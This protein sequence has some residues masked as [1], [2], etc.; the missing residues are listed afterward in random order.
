[1][2]LAVLMLSVLFAAVV[3]PFAATT[4]DG[5][6]AV[7]RDQGFDQRARLAAVQ[8]HAPLAGYRAPG[9][10]G[11]RASKGLSGLAGVIGVLVLAGGLGVVLRHRSPNARGTA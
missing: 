10:V 9:D 2:V 7:A 5:L 6:T 1:M 4:P 11:E 3:A 8:Q